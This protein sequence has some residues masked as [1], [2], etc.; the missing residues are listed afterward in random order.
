MKVY[1]NFFVWL[2]LLAGCKPKVEVAVERIPVA[3]FFRN[4]ERTNYKISPDGRHLAFLAPFEDRMNI[5]VQS[6]DNQKIKQLTSLTD[7]DISMFGWSGNS[8]IYFF[9][10]IDGDENYYLSTVDIEEGLVKELT[11]FENVRT[12]LIDELNNYPDE[13]LIGLNRREASLFDVYSINLSN[14]QLSLVIENPGSYSNFITDE[15]GVIRLIVTTEGTSKAYLF[16][17]SPNHAFKEVLRTD[18]KSFFYPQAFVP[19]SAN[20]VYAVSNINRNTK[21]AVRFDMPQAIELELLFEHPEYDIDWLVISEKD[22]KPLYVQYTD[23]KK[24]FYFM[25]ERAA[26]LYE[27]VRQEIPEDE[28]TFTGSDEEESRVLLRTYSDRS[29]GAFYLFDIELDS[30]MLLA[31]VSPWLNKD[32]MATMQAISYQASDGLTINGYLTLPNDK[33]PKKL[34]MVVVPH[35]GPWLRDV[36]RFDPNVQFLANRGYAV[37]QMNFRGSTGYGR[38]FWTAGFK[39]WGKAMQQDI[40]DGVQYMIAKGI[41]DPSRIAIYGGSYGGYAVLAGLAFTPDLYACGID[42][43]GVS[44]LFTLMQTIP[45]YWEQGREM[46]Y[47]MIGHP[48]KDSLHYV[49]ASPVFHADK[50]TKPLMVVQGAM[51]PRVKKS[52]SDQIV[53]ALAARGIEVDYILREDEGHG[54]RK[55]EN[56]IAL[57]E[58]IEQFLARHLTP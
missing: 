28:I 50:I 53:E 41:A 18:F 44:N 15:N 33:S 7:R 8:R 49:E 30:L 23:W 52:E 10:D 45:P 17:E 35:G 12:Q 6:I 58:S 47:E 46:F 4:P 43:V 51:D 14:G 29:L 9:K 27:R 57:Y 36:W 2:I 24:R 31:D 34:A 11:R 21:A 54:F 55:Q 22:Q 13:M 3:D 26:S 20:E 39:Q 5:F 32:E 1:L 38:E 37:F 16:R 25:D 48:Q 19:G 40:T 42:Y 56:R